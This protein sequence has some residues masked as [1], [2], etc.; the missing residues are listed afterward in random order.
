MKTTRK[1]IEQWTGHRWDEE[2]LMIFVA[3]ATIFLVPLIA[4]CAYYLM[5]S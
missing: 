2:D 5:R 1:I 4:T 3:L